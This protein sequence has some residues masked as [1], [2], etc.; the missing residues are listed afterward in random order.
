MD[1]R[2]I[3]FGDMT[4]KDWKELDKKAKAE[5]DALKEDDGIAA[6]DL[7]NEMVQNIYKTF[8]YKTVTEML[9][10]KFIDV[11]DISCLTH[12]PLKEIK[13]IQLFLERAR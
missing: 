4:D 12:V 10:F 1:L 2:N 6:L 9:Q 3:R 7:Y 11:Y 13:C 8:Q 5:R